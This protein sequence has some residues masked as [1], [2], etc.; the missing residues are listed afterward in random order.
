[1]RGNT[2]RAGRLGSILDSGGDTDWT[3][4]GYSYGAQFAVKSC[5]TGKINV[6]NGLWSLIVNSEDRTRRR[7][8]MQI[9]NLRE[10]PTQHM[11]A[12]SGKDSTESLSLPKH[13]TAGQKFS[14][15]VVLEK[16]Q[17]RFIRQNPTAL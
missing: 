1:M 5:W 13:V 7:H 14:G 8:L 10:R 11:K 4:I 2:V 16:S 15:L 12:T 9:N 3:Y 6:C 17:Q